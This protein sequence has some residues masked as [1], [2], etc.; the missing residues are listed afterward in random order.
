[1]LMLLALS[2][3]SFFILQNPTPEP[4][5]TPAVPLDLTFPTM[6]KDQA[7]VGLPMALQDRYCRSAL[8]QSQQKLYDFLL[9]HLERAHDKLLDISMAYVSQQELDKI[10]YAIRLDNPQLFYYN[11]YSYEY[12]TTEN[13][14]N[15]VVQI[16]FHY[17]Y[18]V[19]KILPMALAIESKITE[20][21]DKSK[22]TTAF[23]RE[24]N[25]QKL[26]LD[27]VTYDAKAPAPSIY[28]AYGALIDGKGVCEAYAESM[29][30]LL[31][32]AGIPCFQVMGQSQKNNHVWLLI[33]LGKDWYHLDPTWNDSSGDPRYY[34]NITQ[35]KILKDHEIKM[36]FSIPL[37][38]STAYN[39]Y[40]YKAEAVLSNWDIA[41]QSKLQQLLTKDVGMHKDTAIFRF[42][43]LKAF[44][45]GKTALIDRKGLGKYL[46]NANNATGSPLEKHF[47]YT[48][49]EDTLSF[50][51]SLKYKKK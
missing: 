27:Q 38:T 47:Q 16:Q 32:S 29:Q 44:T 31:I 7:L 37:A 20:Y 18:P 15:A 9:A 26:L 13:D 14:P 40:F 43:N 46:S 45:A 39:Y 6:P 1:M 10:I 17:D 50:V 25:L 24:W 8:S 3:C 51:V 42:D 35:E 36:P 48:T 41:A 28:N 21:L 23:D 5:P 12:Y 33:K 30:W 22:A 34:F 49:Q 11:G 19:K 2:G 4:S